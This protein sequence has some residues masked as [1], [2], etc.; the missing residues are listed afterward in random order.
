MKTTIRKASIR[1]YD[2]VYEIHS[3]GLVWSVLNK[4]YLSPSKNNKLKYQI[5]TLNRRRYDSHLVHR[6]VA[7]AFIPNPKNKP[8]VNHKNGIKWDNRVEN[9]E[10]VTASENWFHSLET[11]MRKVWAIRV[12][13]IDLVS[14]KILETYPSLT[15]AASK[16]NIQISGISNCCSGLS[17][18]SGGYKW[19]KSQLKK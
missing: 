7:Q 11:G 1:G 6:L 17:K 2:G 10:W 16:N 9:L 14:G 3:N 8:Q 18:S 13:K 5:I 19:E 4:K 12:D 15:E